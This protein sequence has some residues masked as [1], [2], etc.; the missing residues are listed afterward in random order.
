MIISTGANDHM[1]F[2]IS[3]TFFIYLASGYL[4]IKTNPQGN[5]FYN[6]HFIDEAIKAHKC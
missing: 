6:L 1:M 5:Y 3:G 4:L 2:P